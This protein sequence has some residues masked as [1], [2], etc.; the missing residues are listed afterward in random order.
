MHDF[1]YPASL[2]PRDSFGSYL[3]LARFT[4]IERNTYSVTPSTIPSINMYRHILPMSFPDACVKLGRAMDAF[5]VVQLQCN[6]QAENI[7]NPLTRR[8]LYYFRFTQNIRQY[9]T[10]QGQR[11]QRD[12]ESEPE[13]EGETIGA[14]ERREQGSQRAYMQA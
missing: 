13:D 5:A 10:V 14:R 12:S 1:L 9:N 7:T 2:A 4:W 11:T 3:F 6:P 8:R